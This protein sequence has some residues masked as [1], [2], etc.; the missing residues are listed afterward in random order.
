[1]RVSAEPPQ[2]RRGVAQR[3]PEYLQTASQVIGAVQ[4]GVKLGQ[5]VLPYLR[6]LVLAAA[7]K[8]KF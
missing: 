8:A 5:T 6:P 2:S 3:I 4:A 1:M 7:L